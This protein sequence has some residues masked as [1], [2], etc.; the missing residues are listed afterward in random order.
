VSGGD[1]SIFYWPRLQLG[2]SGQLHAPAAFFPA[3]WPPLPIVEETGWTPGP[4]W[5]IWRI[6]DPWTYRNS[7]FHHWLVQLVA[8]RY[9]DS[10]T[11]LC[12]LFQAYYFPG[13]SVRFSYFW[14]LHFFIFSNFEKVSCDMCFS[15]TP[16]LVYLVARK[17]LEKVHWC[18]SL[19][20]VRFEVFTAVTMKNDVFW[21]V[22]PCGSCTNR[23]F[24]GT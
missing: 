10:A 1:G 17:V 5:T 12:P 21:D 4:I 20:I 6:G 7:N 24:W 14:Y 15:K 16:D 13:T 18:N 22:T 3:K 11:G 9:A 8:S 23:R 2:V 19:Q